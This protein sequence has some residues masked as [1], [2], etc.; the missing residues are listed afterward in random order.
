MVRLAA[1]EAGRGA[2]RSDAARPN[3]NG[4]NVAHGVVSADWEAAQAA[5]VVRMDDVRDID[6]LVVV[7]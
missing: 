2:L 6:C 3:V 5:N 1:V 7:A 4:P